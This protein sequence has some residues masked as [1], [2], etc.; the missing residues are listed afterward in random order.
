MIAGVAKQERVHH[1]RNFGSV[2][3][4]R[5]DDQLDKLIRIYLVARSKRY[6]HRC[7]THVCLHDRTEWQL[8]CIAHTIW[9]DNTP[10][11]LIGI[12]PEKAPSPPDSARHTSTIRSASTYL[13]IAK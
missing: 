2:F 1:A 3:V 4:Y 12:I 5:G 10:P 6:V 8:F 13:R 9:S 7:E 11:S